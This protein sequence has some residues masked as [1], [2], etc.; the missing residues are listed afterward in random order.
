PS[1]LRH[2]ADGVPG[3]AERFAQEREI[4]VTIREARIAVQ[5]PLVRF[6]RLVPAVQ[7][8]QQNAEIVEQ[9]G[10]AAA[11]SDG[12]E[13]AEYRLREAAS[14]RPS[15]SE[16]TTRSPTAPIERPESGMASG[17]WRRS[18]FRDFVIRLGGTFAAASA[19]AVRS[20]IR[21]WNENRYDLRG[22]R[23]GDTKPALTRL[24][25]VLRGSRSSRSTSRTP[26]WCIAGGSARAL[27]LR[28]L[29]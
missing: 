16:T 20:T 6:H 26:Y 1:I 7:V 9:Q 22:P 5:G 23:S 14:H 21:S 13:D 18:C 4:V 3:L 15:P 24:R 17:R 25:I 27:C 28:G 10:I 8:F 29:P 12:L 11:G 2:V 19:C